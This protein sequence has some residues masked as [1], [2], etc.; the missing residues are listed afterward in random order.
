MDHLNKT[1][2]LVIFAS[3]ILISLAMHFPN[4]SKDLLSMHVWRQSQTQS[5]ILSFYEEDFNILNPR[6]T[7]RGNGDGIHRMEF[8]LMQWLIASFYKMFGNHLIITRIF[9]F[10]VGLFSVVGLYKLLLAIFRKDTLALIGAWAFNF[11][12]C[13]YYYTINPLPDN[14]ALCCSI[15]GLAFFFSWIRNQRPILLILSGLFLCIGSLCKLPFILYYSV[16]LSYFLLA[17]FEQKETIKKVLT[18]TG[19]LTSLIVLPLIWYASV[20]PSWKGNGIVT[21]LLVNNTPFRET[22]GYFRY[23]FI[24]TLPELL[25]NY[26]S[27]LF[28]LAGFY[29]LFRNKRYKDRSFI[30]FIIWSMAV[31][32][33]YFFEINLIGSVHDYYLFPFYPLLFIIVSYGAYSFMNTRIRFFKYLTFTLLLLLPLTAH[34][35]MVNRWNPDKPGFN[36][37]LLTYKNDLQSAAPNEALCIAGDDESHSIFL[38]YIHKKGWGFSKGLNKQR[39]SEMVEKGAQ[40]LYSDS[41]TVDEDKEI[42]SFLD[43][44][45]IEKGSIK[46]HKLKK[47]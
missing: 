28:F 26:G 44:L 34:L 13:F 7:D 27:V 46:V 40:F 6:H 18:D 47:E 29:F 11:S 22:L 43:T 35:R 5:T 21:G 31:S 15:W 2:K 1:F 17:F 33:Y 3:I 8:P 23:I 36:K 20:V 16:P 12:P 24:S 39:M 4:F 42:M 37:D 25:L 38:Y 19:V 41:R 14:F 10:I 9:T 32:A 30:V 45:V